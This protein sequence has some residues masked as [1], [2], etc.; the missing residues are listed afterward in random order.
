MRMGFEG[1]RRKKRRGK[2]GGKG[3]G[4]EIDWEE[5]KRKKIDGKGRGG[6]ED[7]ERRR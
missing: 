6:M 7:E 1:K 2:M 3:I 4:E 5:E